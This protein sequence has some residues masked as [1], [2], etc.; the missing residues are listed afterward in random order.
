M[1]IGE[2]LVEQNHS[3]SIN[4]VLRHLRDRGVIK[5]SQE[6]LSCEEME[7]NQCQLP[8]NYSEIKREA[9]ANC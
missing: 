3:L 6:E 9:K 5:F 1:Y 2:E 8:S 4:D 7:L